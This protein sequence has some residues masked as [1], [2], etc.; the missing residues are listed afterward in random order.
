MQGYCPVSYHFG[1]PAKGNPAF[2]S[3]RDGA[4]YRFASKEGKD[5][6]DGGA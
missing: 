4:V 1:P 2:T 3:E 6:F 5:L